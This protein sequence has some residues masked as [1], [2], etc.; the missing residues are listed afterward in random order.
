[1]HLVAARTAVTTLRPL[2]VLRG[3]NIAMADVDVQDAA[4]AFT[5]YLG[6]VMASMSGCISAGI[7]QM[8]LIGC[9]V[10]SV[11]TAMGG[12]TLRDV[13]LGRPPFWLTLP[14]HLHLCIWTSVTIFMLWPSVV[15]TGFKDTHL[16]F[17]WSDAIGM[18]ASAIIGAHIGMQETG[19]WAVGVC[20]GLV[21]AVFGGIGRDI[22]CLE[23]PRALYAERSMYAT[24]ALLGSAC[25]VLLYCMSEYLG[26]KYMP[27]WVVAS[28]PFFLA[29]LLRAA[30]WTYRLALPR[31]ARKAP[32]GLFQR[33]ESIKVD[34]TPMKP[35]KAQ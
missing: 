2:L 6:T 18:A 4:V 32:A 17:L 12:G 15:S 34:L 3:G 31:W 9:I 14:A 25:Y 19:Q 28:V 23:P 1:M 22:L 7:K 8:D 26:A 11:M 16:A 24:P 35:V 27:D 10:C 29:L 5:L 21:T 13:I 20:S 33:Q 30:A